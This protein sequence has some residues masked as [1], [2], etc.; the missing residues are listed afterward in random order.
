MDKPCLDLKSHVY[1]FKPQAPSEAEAITAF[2]EGCPKID[3]GY[4]DELHKFLWDE[5][6]A[7]YIM[8]QNSV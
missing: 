2:L 5:G 8:V 4:L 3:P 6:Q 1:T 7:V